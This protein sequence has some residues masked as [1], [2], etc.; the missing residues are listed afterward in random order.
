MANYCPNCGQELESDWRACPKCGERVEPTPSSAGVSEQPSGYFEGKGQPPPPETKP[1]EV[2][3]TTERSASPMPA[4]ATLSERVQNAWQQAT[5]PVGCPGCKQ[6]SGTPGALCPAC[7]SRYPSPRTA[8]VGIGIAMLG[9]F[10][11]LITLV[12]TGGLLEQ[13]ANG[14]FRGGTL[15]ALGWLL[16]VVGIGIAIYGV[17]RV[18]PARQTSCCGCSCAVALFVLPA[19]GIGLWMSG[20][21]VL[22]AAALPAWLPLSL[23]LDAGLFF[24]SALKNMGAELV[25]HARAQFQRA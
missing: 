5:G 7:G 16:G 6:T 18:G 14:D 9:G 24:G 17:G 4:G 15:E 2:K 19:A 3:A 22:A 21:P 11:L 13:K 25:S 10:L 20:G 12:A 8:M 23:G 1:T